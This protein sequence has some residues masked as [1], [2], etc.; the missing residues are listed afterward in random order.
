MTRI[1]TLYLLLLSSVLDLPTLA[2]Y[3]W[4][5]IHRNPFFRRLRLEARSGPEPQ[6]LPF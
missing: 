3:K 4:V 2:K 1:W 5:V 6:Q